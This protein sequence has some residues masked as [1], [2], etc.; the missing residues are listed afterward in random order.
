[1]ALEE[2]AGGEMHV[3]DDVNRINDIY[4]NTENE[5]YMYRKDNAYLYYKFVSVHLICEWH[6]FNFNKM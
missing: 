6:V 5:R 4:C 1:M 3:A 2:V